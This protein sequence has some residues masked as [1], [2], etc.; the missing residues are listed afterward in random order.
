MNSDGP[1]LAQTSPRTE[2]TRA[3]PHL[4][5]QFCAKTPGHLKTRK[6]SRDTIHLSH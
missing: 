2:E 1:N 4:R 3:H 6:E 5:W